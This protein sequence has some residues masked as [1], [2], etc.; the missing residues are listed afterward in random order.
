[1]SICTFQCPDSGLIV[2]IEL[3]R[4]VVKVYG[5]EDDWSEMQADESTKQAT[6]EWIAHTRNLLKH[7]RTPA[8]IERALGGELDGSDLDELFN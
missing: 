5:D 1:M 2:V 7:C 4:G 6:R 8:E 3:H